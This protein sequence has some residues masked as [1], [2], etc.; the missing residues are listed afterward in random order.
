MIY[1]QFL[2]FDIQSSPEY[3]T[4]MSFFDTL[5]HTVCV[6]ELFTSFTSSLEL[7]S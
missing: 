2:V 7:F 4:Q 6:C 1:F 5:V 3:K